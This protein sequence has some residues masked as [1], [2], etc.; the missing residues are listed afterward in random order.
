MRRTASTPTTS[1]GCHSLEAAG[2]VASSLFAIIYYASLV[3]VALQTGLQRR[4]CYGKTTETP[5][6]YGKISGQSKFPTAARAVHAN[7]IMCE[8]PA[9]F[10]PS[11]EAGPVLA[12]PR[13]VSFETS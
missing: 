7:S 6:A 10:T 1:E 8:H 13:N 11:P 12:P 3:A 4:R 5:I 9:V 2:R